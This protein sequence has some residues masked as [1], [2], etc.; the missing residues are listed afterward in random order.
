MS[1]VLVV[2][3]NPD[4]CQ[5]LARLVQFVN[6]DAAWVTSGEEALKFLKEHD[7]DL[8]ILDMMMP[9]MDGL[10]VLRLVRLNPDTARLPVVMFSAVSDPQ[11]RLLAFARGANDYWLKA[12]YDYKGLKDQLSH[13]LKHANE[14]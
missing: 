11:S 2:D 13:L 6:G 8:M 3:D 1:M 7:V 12:S 14:A 5:M 10:E 4:A 9:G